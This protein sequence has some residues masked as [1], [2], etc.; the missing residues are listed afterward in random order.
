MSVKQ[1]TFNKSKTYWPIF[2]ELVERQGLTCYYCK[3]PLIDINRLEE[4]YSFTDGKWEI[5]PGYGYPEIEH[6]LPRSRGGNDSIDNL[7]LSYDHC[8][9]KK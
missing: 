8:N 6:K 4:Y 5:K 3:I 2:R 9:R 1:E 7:V